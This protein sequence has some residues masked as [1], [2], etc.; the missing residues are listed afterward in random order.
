MVCTPAGYEEAE[1]KTYFL[2]AN[3][4]FLFKSTSTREQFLAGAV[5]ELLY[6]TDRNKKRQKARIIDK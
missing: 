6:S 5:V 1:R 4:E 3:T 2:E